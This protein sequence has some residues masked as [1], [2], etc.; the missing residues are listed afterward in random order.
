MPD[1]RSEKFLREHIDSI[2]AFYHP[3]VLDKKLG[4][5]HQNFRD[6]GSVF[7]P[8]HKHLVSSTRMIF[9]Y[10]RAFDNCIVTG[11]KADYKAL[12]EV[13]LQYL[14]EC[15]WDNT[16]RGYHWVLDN[17][18]P[19]D[20]T[21]HCYGLAF[22]ILALASCVKS[23]I[24]DVRDELYFTWNLLNEKFWQSQQGLYADEA[25]A[26]WRSLSDYRGQNANMHC[27]EAL[28][29]AH[30]ATG[31][32]VFLNRAYNLTKT[33]AVNLANKSNGLIW[34]H[35]TEDLQI[36]WG[37]N[38]DDPKNLYRPWGFQPGHQTEWAKLLLL[39]YRV[40]PESWM[41]QR[42]IELFDHALKR[43]WDRNWGGILYG[44][45][46][47]GS[48]CD[49]DKYFWVQAESF[50]AAALLAKV[51]GDEQYWQWYDK[52]WQYSWE[53]FVDHNNGAWYRLLN[54]RNQRYSEEKSIAGAKCDYHTL[55]A[56]WAV[57]DVIS[58]E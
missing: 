53:H 40:R 49:D 26:D 31:D 13:G 50:A 44:H 56:C 48:I 22:V 21:N 51:T 24:G 3:Q 34:E 45:A 57:L 55:G 14:R 11:R 27:C 1:F 8:G 33:I 58:T 7:A 17:N 18:Q 10:C 6:D 47:D 39:L 20:Q 42:A 12:A 9:N 54:C 19:A 36:D 32:S 37:Y 46:P 16:R 2:L 23:G 5:F 28:L 29:V 41:V 25:T 43:C 30:C 35:F 52:I 15:H 4:G 38:R